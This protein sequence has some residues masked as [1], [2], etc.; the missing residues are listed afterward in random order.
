MTLAQLAVAWVL[1]HP[2][3]TAAIVGARN[4]SQAAENVRAADV[5]LPEEVKA[6]MDEL[7]RAYA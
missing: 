1:A 4:A 5:I 7:A 6:Q 3:V 2:A